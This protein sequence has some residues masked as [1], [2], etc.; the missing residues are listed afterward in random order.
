MPPFCRI[1]ATCLFQ[2]VKTPFG[3]LDNR[4]S[5]VARMRR[6][7]VFIFF[8]LFSCILLVWHRKSIAHSAKTAL[9]AVHF[10][11][12]CFT[13]DQQKK[14]IKYALRAFHT[15]MVA[16]N[17]TYWLEGGTLLGA[18]RRS[19]HIPWDHDADLGYLLAERPRFRKKVVGN[20]I[21]NYNITMNPSN[22]VSMKYG[23][24]EI[25]IF[26][27]GTYET[28]GIGPD[29]VT[30]TRAT[31]RNSDYE[32]YFEDMRQE[33]L[34]PIRFCRFEDLQLLCPNKTYEVLRR[35]Y[36]VTFPLFRFPF[37]LRC[38]LWPPHFLRIF[39]SGWFLN[40]SVILW[41]WT[42]FGGP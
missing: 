12:S 33:W 4:L 36:P 25:D 37:K 13:D 2:R 17:L 15:E 19:G 31:F 22:P 41:K 27:Y 28:L 10:E 7:R 35:R 8:T 24:G 32:E 5:Q 1:S 38:L 21:R 42:F 11:Q 9:I 18:Y 3:S 20:L 6:L 23:R 34:F 40:M 16:N 14:D 29:N 26:A 30:L 39:F